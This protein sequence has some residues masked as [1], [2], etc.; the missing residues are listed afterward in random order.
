M[1]RHVDAT[2]DAE[3]AAFLR[4]IAASAGATRGYEEEAAEVAAEADEEMAVAA[5]ED[6]PAKTH[7]FAPIATLERK[8]RRYPAH[9]HGWRFRQAQQRV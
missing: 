6:P 4:A 1:L 8:A 2:V 3:R 5:A 7:D 9:R